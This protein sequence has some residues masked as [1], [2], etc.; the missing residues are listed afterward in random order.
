MI[1]LIN[2]ACHI[3]CVIIVIIYTYKNI[4]NYCENED[5][6]E[7]SYKSFHDDP[8]A[9][10]P[11][12]TVCFMTP[13]PQNILL[14]NLGNASSPFDYQS[15]L[16]GKNAKEKHFNE[17][18]Y[19]NVSMHEEDFLNDVIINSK[20]RQKLNQD[21]KKYISVQSWGWYL[22]VMKCFTFDVPFQ[23]GIK[24]SAMHLSINNSIFPDS[25][26]PNDGW[27]SY[28]MQFFF[29][30]PKQFI[31]SF[32]TNKRFWSAKISSQNS[33]RLRYSLLEME[34]LRKR[35]KREEQCYKNELMPY[36]DWMIYRI[37]EEV[38][39]KPPYWENVSAIDPFPVC[40][41]S[42][43]LRHVTNLFWNYFYGINESN[44]PCNEI[45]KMDIVYQES[46][47]NETGPP[48]TTVV[49]FYYFKCNEYKEI[50]QMQA[51]TG[52]VLVGNIGGFVGMLL[53]FALV[54]IPG[55]V[56]NGFHYVKKMF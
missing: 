7:V 9:I 29:H 49:N 12:L 23:K 22:G 19:Q 27:M 40:K 16:I 51:Y 15:H 26:R 32:P 56:N 28:G 8:R 17:V 13:F 25:I 50:R 55:I 21:W 39:C 46:K 5:L 1:K 44:T 54:Q 35:D 2:L 48:N 42:Q 34:V 14:M 43:E 3:I 10:Y 36:D 33:Y 41:T 6:C 52:A 37:V 31:R 24:V 38:N 18:S 30:F 45:K 4:F 20:G 11:S 53:G 47:Y